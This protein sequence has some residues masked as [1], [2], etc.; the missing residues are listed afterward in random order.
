MYK[1]WHITGLTLDTWIRQVSQP[2]GLNW[3]P[4]YI[5]PGSNLKGDISVVLENMN[6]HDWS[7][8]RGSINEMDLLA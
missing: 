5:L 4:L 3:E 8:R 1:S 6:M 2:R 7:S